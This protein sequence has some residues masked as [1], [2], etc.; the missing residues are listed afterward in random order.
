MHEVADGYITIKSMIDDKYLEIS[1]L[2]GQNRIVNKIAGTWERFKLE[3][4][5]F[6]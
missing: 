4:K 5:S 3:K 2:E 1:D 6:D